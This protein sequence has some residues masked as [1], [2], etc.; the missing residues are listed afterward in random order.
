LNLKWKNSQEVWED[1]SGNSY[2]DPGSQEIWDY[3]A[4]IA[5]TAYDL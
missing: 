2:S 5:K 4:A 3:H 1:H